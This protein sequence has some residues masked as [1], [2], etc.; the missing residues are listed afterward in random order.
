MCIDDQKKDQMTARRR[1][2]LNLT[3]SKS[4]CLRNS[5]TIALIPIP[6]TATAIATNTKKA[7]CTTDKDLSG[8]HHQTIL[9]SLAVASKYS[10]R[11]V[12]RSL[13]T[14]SLP[15]SSVLYFSHCNFT[16]L[17]HREKVP[18]LFCHSALLGI[19]RTLEQK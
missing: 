4:K 1:I 10:I 3:T 9:I 14:W 12:I 6:T 17:N 16:I 7:I 11:L 19:H 5:W 2:L 13:E 18:V 15:Y 8:Y